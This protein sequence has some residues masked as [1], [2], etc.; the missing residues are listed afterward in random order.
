MTV[1]A[2]ISNCVTG[3]LD[4]L[5]RGGV[6]GGK[7]ADTAARLL[8]MEMGVKTSVQMSG[9]GVVLRA[10]TRLSTVLPTEERPDKY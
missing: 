2:K 5:D 8:V 4:V 3:G 9:D 7:R 10:E 6:G 1:V